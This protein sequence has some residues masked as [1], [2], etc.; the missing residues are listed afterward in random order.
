M[1][2][3]KSKPRC[4]DYDPHGRGNMG[5][6]KNLNLPC[7]NM[8]HYDLCPRENHVKQCSHDGHFTSRDPPE[9]CPICGGNEYTE[10]VVEAEGGGVEAQVSAA[11]EVEPKPGK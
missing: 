2:E 5:Y 8:R 7:M 1:G 11:H 10:V 6:C 9:T 3:R 4:P